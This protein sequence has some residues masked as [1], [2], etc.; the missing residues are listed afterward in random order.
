MDQ[1]VK[2]TGVAMLYKRVKLGAIF[3]FLESGCISVCLQL[4]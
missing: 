2:T 3:E 4:L 1:E